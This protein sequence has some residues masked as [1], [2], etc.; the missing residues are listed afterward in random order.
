[1]TSCNTIKRV[2]E[3][4]HLLTDTS[5]FVNDK[6]DL[7]ETVNSL[8]YQ[9]RNSKLLGVPLRLHI[10][11]L[12]K[13]QPDSAYTKW[14]NKRPNRK[15]RLKGIYSNKQVDKLGK[16]YVG[17]NNWLKK[18]GEAPVIIDSA[19]TRKSR[20][21][22]ESYFWQNGWFDVE[23][24]SILKPKENQ[25]A[26][27]DYFVTTGKPYLIDSISTKIAS[28][29][30]DSLYQKI[31]KK[32]LI[33]PIEQFRSANFVNERDRIASEL[34]NSGVYHFT[35]DYVFFDIDSISND[36]KVNVDLHI[37]HR[38]VKT[39]DSTRREPFKIYHIKDVNILTDYSYD[40][41]NKVIKDSVTYNDYNL[42]SVNGL[43]YRPK[44]LT[45][46]VFITPGEIYKDIDRTRTYR[47]LS[48]LKTFKYPNIEYIENEADT[49][50]TANIFLTPRKKYS[51]GA[52][53]DVTQSNIQTVGFS[54]SG[55]VLT[56][57][58]FR[59]AETLELSAIGSIGASKDPSDSKDQFFDI[60]E[61][62][63]NLRLTIPRFFS[64]FNTDKIVPKYMSPS[65]RISIG[66]TSQRNI[67]LDKQTLSGIYNYRW[68]PSAAITDR[69]D[70]FNV[71]FVKNL[72]TDN[73][74]EVY[75]NSY[76][77]LNT[78]AQDI[79]YIG[80]NETLAIPEGADNFLVDA[81]SA[82]PPNN[83]T[84]AQIQSVNNINE[85]KERLTEDNLIF[86][87]NFGFTKDKRE[88]LF[89]NDFSIFRAKLEL[90]GNSLTALTKLAGQKKNANGKYEV[91][92]VA[93]SQYVKTELDY[94]KH[95]GLGSKSVLAV[96]SFF[97]FAIPFGNSTSI[98]FSRSFFAGGTN[99]N[100]AWTAYN[101]GPGT[102]SSSNEFNEANLKLAYNVEL[103]YNLFGNFN[104]AFFIDAGNIWNA[105]DDVEDSDAI[106]NDFSSLG[107]IAI[108]AGFGLRYD[109]SFFVLRFDI[110]FK[111]HD[112]S[113][114]DQ[115]R[116]FNDFNFKNAVYN[117]GIN[118]P[119]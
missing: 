48:E 93:F 36:K 17:L 50:L 15:R 108:G 64:P 12:A 101:L 4:E 57:N 27:I 118:Y 56:R 70:L 11:N 54:F 81:L 83:I 98:P 84:A 119:F 47:Y 95:W 55:N 59:G 69:L 110:G 16:S 90:A 46:A 42:Y 88:N 61:L 66:A 39:E 6:R 89:D 8:L 103:R 32:S 82:T 113:Y 22:L 21:R 114:K 97:G 26:S 62:G 14:L 76:S 1:M 73:Y 3:N 51:L 9:K 2:G 45:D 10:Y 104:G 79:G 63:A 115:N 19:K 65:T 23:T 116:W 74:F 20:N 94:V 72:N 31:K 24:S 102:T 75:Q 87:S 80:A 34:R 29:V 30:V 71:Q 60:N 86:A 91:F 111:A 5:V 100:R 18:T 85:R 78:I 52:S 77:T 112:P 109:F 13:E 7:S 96:R 58:I 117:I 35:Q 25:R 92:G 41:R 44:A 37:P 53:F 99:D 40:N 105:L 49:T 107:D 28:P 106:F 67:G 38:I 43:K 33:Q 68:Y